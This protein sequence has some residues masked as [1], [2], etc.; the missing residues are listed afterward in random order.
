MTLTPQRLFVTLVLMALVGTSPVSAQVFGT[1]TWQMQPYCNLVTLTLTQVPGGYTI[2]GSDNQCGAAKVGG[3]GGMALINPD[4]TV[5]LEFTVV[6]APAGKAVHVSASL[7][8]ATGSG[9][10][11]D[12]VGNSGTLALGA[13]GSGSPRPLPASGV[14]AATITAAELAP[15]A[16]TGAAVADASLTMI[17]MANGPRLVGAPPTNQ[18]KLTTSDTVYDTV[19]VTAPSAGKVLVLS[20]G[21]FWFNDSSTIVEYP[22]CS[23][24]T[25]TV[26][27]AAVMTR[28]SDFGATNNQQ[29]ASWHLS[30]VFAVPAP[31][32]FT[33]NL[34]C[35]VFNP[36][37]TLMPPAQMSALFV[38]Q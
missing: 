15:G 4:G 2:D 13:P 18:V 14:S 26:Q 6:T 9:P 27:N 8:P 3:A 29:F 1:F 19:T 31:G 17:D 33:M 7:S 20:S 21:V 24:T 11:N 10:W 16:V 25:G 12:S 37:N 35:N 5:G 36:T 34:V 32:P 23:L 28:S 22:S 38:A 30:H